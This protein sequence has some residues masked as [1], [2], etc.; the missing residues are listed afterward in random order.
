[1]SDVAKIAAR[2]LLIPVNGVYFDQIAAGEKAEEYRLCTPFW[3]KR[4]A[5]R[6]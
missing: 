4:L 6:E 2:P 5:G 1:M 3:Q